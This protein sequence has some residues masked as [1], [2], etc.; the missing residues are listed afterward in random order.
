MLGRWLKRMTWQ[1]RYT[2]KCIECDEL[3][4]ENSHLVKTYREAK[5]NVALAKIAENIY[6]QRKAARDETGGPMV[7]CGKCAN[8]VFA[9]EADICGLCALDRFLDELPQP[10]ADTAA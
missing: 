9:S 10:E 5:R 1:Q 2:E 8:F 3:R 6:L 7:K 4:R